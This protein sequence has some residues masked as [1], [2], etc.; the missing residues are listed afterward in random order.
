MILFVI[1][2]IN[3][4]RCEKESIAT[5]QIKDWIAENKL[6]MVGEPNV[7]GYNLPWT[8]PYL[9]NNEIIAVK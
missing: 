5:P 7:A 9:R 3:I 2:E 8:I 1:R 4:N 6:E